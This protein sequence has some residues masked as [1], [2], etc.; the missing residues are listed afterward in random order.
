MLFIER[1]GGIYNMIKSEKKYAYVVHQRDELH[2][3]YVLTY[4]MVLQMEN[5]CDTKMASEVVGATSEARGSRL[6]RACLREVGS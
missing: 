2:I 1:D 6:P 5:I 3:Y 4:A